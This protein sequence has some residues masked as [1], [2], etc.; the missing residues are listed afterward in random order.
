MGRN[1]N[2]IYSEYKNNTI[3]CTHPKE[4]TKRK[5]IF[6]NIKIKLPCKIFVN[7]QVVCSYQKICSKRP[8]FPTPQPPEKK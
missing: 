4:P 2:C 5:Y 7:S 3:E 6:G 8:K 1:I